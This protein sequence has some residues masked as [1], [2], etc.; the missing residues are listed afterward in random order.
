MLRDEAV[1]ELLRS[2]WEE[3]SESGFTWREVEKNRGE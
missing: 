1:E 2:V 3:K